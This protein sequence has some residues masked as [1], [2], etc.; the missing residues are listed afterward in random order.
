[1][2]T[3]ITAALALVLLA[4]TAGAALAQDHRGGRGAGAAADGGNG[5]QFQDTERRD[6]MGGADNRGQRRSEFQAD[7]PRGGPPQA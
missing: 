6:M 2:K 7:Q 5:P 4:G 1:M 3:T